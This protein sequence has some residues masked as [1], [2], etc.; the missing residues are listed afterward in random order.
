M[1]LSADDPSG[2]GAAAGRPEAIVALYDRYGASLFRVACSLIR[3]PADAEDA[4]QEV[5]L[6]LVRGHT[7]LARICNPRAYLFAALRR[8]ALRLAERRH[9]EMASPAAAFEEIAAPGPRTIDTERAE[10][11]ERA[12]RSLPAE[13]RELIALKIDGALSFAEIA[14]VLNISPNTAASRYRYAIEKLRIALEV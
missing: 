7:E 8:A 11:L 4:V 9:A 12:L 5:F 6:G 1:G 3:S 13:Q 14:E 2:H 10:Q